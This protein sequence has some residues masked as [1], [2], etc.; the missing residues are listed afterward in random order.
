MDKNDL[1][2]IAKAA[3]LANRAHFTCKQ[4]RKGNG[5]PYIIHPYRVATLVA[6]AGGNANQIAAA[7]CH[8]VLEDCESFREEACATLPASV[9]ALVKEL[10]KAEISPGKRV[11]GEAFMAEL[12]EMSPEAKLVKLCDRLDN[13]RDVRS[14]NKPDWARTYG[15]ESVEVLKALA[16]NPATG[17]QAEALTASIREQIAMNQ[18][19]AE[20]REALARDK[21][22]K[23]A[24]N[25]L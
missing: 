25:A 1:A 8:D 21:Q 15:A 23:G 10:T 14:A 24:S 3:E 16:V 6:E 22:G 4:V 11:K 12:R 20:Q 13:L 19:W 18:A 7:W 2:M 5:L 17:P 9:L